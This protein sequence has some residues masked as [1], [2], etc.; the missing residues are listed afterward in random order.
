[1]C[2]DSDLGSTTLPIR[3]PSQIL[4]APVTPTR[5]PARARP[6][7][8]LARLYDFQETFD[9]SRTAQ[10]SRDSASCITLAAKHITALRHCVW[11]SAPPLLSFFLP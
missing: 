6:G 4:P 1:M 3:D 8:L 2:S 10:R 5:K 9:Q 11:S 7:P